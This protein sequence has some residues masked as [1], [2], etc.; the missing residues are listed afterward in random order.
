MNNECTEWGLPASHSGAANA[1]YCTTLVPQK[2]EQR[3]KQNLAIASATIV[4]GL[5]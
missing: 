5:L 3:I 2:N 4:W 1:L